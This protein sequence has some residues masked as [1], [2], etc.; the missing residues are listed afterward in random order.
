M[1]VTPSKIISTYSDIDH[2]CVS[3]SPFTPAAAK[4]EEGIVVEDGHSPTLPSNL[5][6]C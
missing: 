2:K 5:L 1:I 3:C 6:L 4:G